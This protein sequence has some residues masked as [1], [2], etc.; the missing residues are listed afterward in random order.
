MGVY[1]YTR[2]KGIKEVAGMKIARFAFAY[3]P[4][5]G[6][7]V[8]RGYNAMVG[9]MEAFAKSAAYDCP[10]AEHAIMGEW[11]EIPDF[12]ECDPRYFKHV[13]K[14]RKGQHTLIDDAPK[15]YVGRLVKNARGE[16]AFEPDEM[17]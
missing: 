11:K 5:R 3:K 7:S 9:R 13:F 16:I 2:R 12:S 6:W 17:G 8:P 1:V 15:E 4:W 10:D 14:I